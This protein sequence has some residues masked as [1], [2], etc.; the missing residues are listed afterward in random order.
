MLVAPVVLLS[1]VLKYDV[2]LTSLAMHVFVVCVLNV[3]TV[4]IADDDDSP[5]ISGERGHLVDLCM[6]KTD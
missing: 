3:I 4:I 6:S 2:T 1:L 5:E